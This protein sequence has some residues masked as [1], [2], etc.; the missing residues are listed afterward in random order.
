MR[1]AC[2]VKEFLDCEPCGRGNSTTWKLSFLPDLSLLLHTGSYGVYA[3]NVAERQY[4]EKKL[5]TGS[6]GVYAHTGSV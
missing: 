4:Q 6:Y 3:G 1:N 5:H 2:A